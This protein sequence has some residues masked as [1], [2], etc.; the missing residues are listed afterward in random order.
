MVAIA[1]NI[2]AEI[3]ELNQLL[4]TKD[5]VINLVK[6]VSGINKLPI[7]ESNGVSLNPEKYHVSFDGV[8]H[9]LPRKEFDLLYYLMCNKNKV[10]RRTIIL[11]DVWGTD[12]WVGE[13]TIDVHIRK[14]R[15]KFNV[16][17]IQNI[18]GVGYI[19]TE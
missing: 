8:N 1:N 19:W 7:I 15:S 3:Q 4:L 17:N 16:P 11:R 12:I 14:I 9:V 2:I 18:K 5:E 13:R 10:M 6:R